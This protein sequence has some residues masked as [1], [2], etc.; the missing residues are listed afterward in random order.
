MKP[1]FADTSYFLALV[2]PQD[3]W[4]RRAVELTDQLL[5]QVFV[6]EY[7][8]VEL[9]SMLCRDQDREV[10]LATVRD[11]QSDPAFRIIA[12]SSALF[13]RGLQLFGSRPDKEWSLVDC[14]SF[15]VMKERR[16]TGALTA[17]HHFKQAGF[18]ALL[19]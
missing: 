6:T 4:Y 18:N 7:V 8:L 13:E 1:A 11:V 12:A 17:D 15:V 5:G 3:A 19:T 10:Y 14:I 16:L 9:A 2:G